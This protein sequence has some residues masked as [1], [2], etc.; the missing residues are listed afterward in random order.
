MCG[1]QNSHE[2]T[3]ILNYI[4]I[5]FPCVDIHNTYKENNIQKI[6]ETKDKCGHGMV[7]LDG[8]FVNYLRRC[9]PGN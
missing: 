5:I 6:L 3:F 7:Y 2:G 9:Y 8:K 1:V 4:Y